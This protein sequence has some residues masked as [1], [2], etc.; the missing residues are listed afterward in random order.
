MN[1]S[2]EITP[3][4][5]AEVLN[6]TDTEL[7]ARAL[8]ALEELAIRTAPGARRDALWAAVRELRPYTPGYRIALRPDHDGYLDD[9]VVSDVSCFRME[10]MGDSWWLCCY[11]ADSDDRVVFDVR[12]SG[13]KRRLAVTVVE[14]PDPTVVTYEPGASPS[15]VTR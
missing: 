15:D 2:D 14:A 1:V 11:L 5:R 9:V 6:A 4:D 12:T 13:T 7:A 3:V 10:D 8:L